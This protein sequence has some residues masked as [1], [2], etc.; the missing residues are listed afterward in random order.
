[1]ASRE[2]RYYL[3]D[4]CSGIITLHRS[5][6]FVNG[7]CAGCGREFDYE[8]PDEEFSLPGNAEDPQ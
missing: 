5:G 8:L 7:K 6:I 3:C 4:Q 1:M 2:T